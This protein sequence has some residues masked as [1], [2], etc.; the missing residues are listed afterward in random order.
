M[1]ESAIPKEWESGKISEFT[2]I[3]M[4]LLVNEGGLG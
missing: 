3:V 2:Y 1:A 4:G